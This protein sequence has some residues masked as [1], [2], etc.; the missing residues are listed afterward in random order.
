MTSM[1]VEIRVMLKDDHGRSFVGIGIIWLLRGIE[2]HRSISSA[3]RDM[4]LSYPKA[5][6]I[7]KNL[8]EGL[9]RQILVRR[10]GGVGRGGAELTPF[11]REFLRRYERMQ[12]RISR[13]AAVAFEK[14]FARP[15]PEG[16][17]P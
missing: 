16:G 14:E 12:T 3:A 5:L 13:F 11:G 4:S 2:R 7:I 9:G 17:L 10:K 1:Q 15:L 8:E 6:R